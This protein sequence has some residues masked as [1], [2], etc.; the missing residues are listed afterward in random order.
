MG[1]RP[2]TRGLR[3]PGRVGGRGGSTLLRGVEVLLAA[4]AWQGTVR[5]RLCM[6]EEEKGKWK[7]WGMG[8]AGG[9][10]SWLGRGMSAL[11]PMGCW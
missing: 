3:T 9:Q 10:S 5:Q 7:G 8:T 11:Q 6:G 1:L 2:K 4:L